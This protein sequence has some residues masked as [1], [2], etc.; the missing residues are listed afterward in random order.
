MTDNRQAPTRTD[1]T[2]NK[3]EVSLAVYRK[4]MAGTTREERPAR[5]SFSS[6]ALQIPAFRLSTSP[7]P[8]PANIRR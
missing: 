5:S 6:T 1:Y 2:V 7:F 3:G 8:A 4:C